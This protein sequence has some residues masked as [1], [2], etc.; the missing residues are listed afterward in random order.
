M[1]CILTDASYH[2]APRR[3][4]AIL[5]GFRTGEMTYILK[6]ASLYAANLLLSLPDPVN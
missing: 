6:A 5:A 2:R 3:C 1:S 4:Q